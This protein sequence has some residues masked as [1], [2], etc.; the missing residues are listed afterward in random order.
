MELKGLTLTSSTR[1]DRMNLGL[2]LDF[3]NPKNL[4]NGKL[5]PYRSKRMLKLSADTQLA[6]WTLG[7]EAQLYS[8]RFVDAENSAT[9]MESM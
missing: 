8:A 4:E 1:L 2:S 9:P 5:L 3:L 6:G 7:T